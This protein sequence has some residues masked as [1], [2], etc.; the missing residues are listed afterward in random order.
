MNVHIQES[1]KE[2]KSGKLF[3]VPTP[4]GNLEDITFRALQTLKEVDLIAAEDTRHT[5]KLLNH[6]DIKNNLIS[7]H[8]HSKQSRKEQLIAKLIEGKHIALVSD[9]GMPTISDPGYDLIKAAIEQDISVVVLP[10]ANAA[11]CALVGSGLPSNEYLFYGFLPRKKNEQDAELERLKNIQATLIFYESPYRLADTLQNITKSLGN[12]QVV[13]AREIT[14]IH[15]TYVRGNARD[16]LQWIKNHPVKGE[17]CIVVEGTDEKPKQIA[18]WEKFTIEEH[19]KH[20][21]Q[22]EKMSHKLAL[23]QVATDRNISKRDVYQAIHVK[24]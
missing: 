24:K 1:Y 23:K 9:A 10:G 3:I 6:F 12:R 15:E 18:W 21:E 11:L 17:C 20:Y 8:E 4:I 14:K 19:V 5:Q 22:F 13:I 7:Y 2:S 16:V